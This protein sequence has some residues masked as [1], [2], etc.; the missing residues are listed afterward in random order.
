MKRRRDG[1]EDLLQEL[2]GPDGEAAARA[3]Y[4]AHGNELYG[5]AFNRLR[6]RGLAEE[7]V[8]EVFTRV[9]RR[10][11]EFDAA[12]GGLRPWLYGIARNAAIDV[13]RH[14]ARR[15]QLARFDADP[16]DGPVHEPIEDALVRWQAQEAFD[17]LT[18]EHREVLRLGNFGDL[19]VKEIAAVTGLAEGTVRSRTYYALRSLRLA[20]EEMG[21]HP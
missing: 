10:A 17:G 4:G 12:R 19:T 1:D 8:Q 20:Q 15:P 3:L 7:V 18:R 9:W 21:V 14:R 5:F 2:R 6:D 16:D 11:G 13:E